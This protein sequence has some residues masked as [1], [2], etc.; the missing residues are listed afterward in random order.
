LVAGA[1]GELA[2]AGAES[3]SR[4]RL[5]LGDAI[6]RASAAIAYG[7]D[8]GEAPIKRALAGEGEVHIVSSRGKRSPGNRATMSAYG[9]LAIYEADPPLW[10]DEGATAETH[11]FASPSRD[12]FAFFDTPALGRGFPA[13]ADGRSRE[14]RVASMEEGV[15]EM[16]AVA[17]P[18]GPSLKE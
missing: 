6:S 11:G 12:G 5:V 2:G 13:K 18:N 15:G 10:P 4:G 7:R 3:L 17:G 16:R 9:G 8:H 1:A 14:Q